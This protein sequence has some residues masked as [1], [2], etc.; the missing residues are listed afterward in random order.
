MS[1]FVDLTGQK[2][3]KL[4]V[5]ERVKSPT[6]SDHHAYWICKCACGNYVVVI[7]KD[8]RNNHTRSC[9]C[10]RK[11]RVGETHRTHGK[12]KDRLFFVWQS[13]INRCNN[14]KDK[15]Y[16]YY[17]GRGITVCDEWRKFEPFC[18]WVMANGYND[19]LTIERNDVNGNYEPTNCRWAT[20]KEQA[21][22]TRRNHLITYNG[23]SQTISQW[24]EEYNMKYSTLSSRLNKL[25]WGVEKALKTK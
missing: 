5:I 23:K 21:N 1:K 25:R 9:G 10:L 13:M 22:N 15:S 8:L 4:T 17:G 7:G 24:A 6:N 19:S 2:F 11:Q 20:R 3:G 18:D 16:N 14:E 12:S